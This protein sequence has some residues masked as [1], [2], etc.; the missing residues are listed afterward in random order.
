MSEPKEGDKFWIMG[1]DW[2]PLAEVT[3]IRTVI[4]AG[5][6]GFAIH[7]YYG[8]YRVSH[9]ETGALVSTGMD[10]GEAFVRAR[11]YVKEKGGKE[12]ILSMIRRLQTGISDRKGKVNV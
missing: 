5:V 10:D 1:M 3:I 6:S 8:E 4:L 9:I 2:L 7:E 12:G 11:S